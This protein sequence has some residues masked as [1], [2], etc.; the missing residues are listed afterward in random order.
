MRRD[1][2]WRIEDGGL[3][4]VDGSRRKQREDGMKE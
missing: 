4:V 1:R 3:P 2:K